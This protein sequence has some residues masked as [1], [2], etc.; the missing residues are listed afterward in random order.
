MAGTGNA[1]NNVLTGNDLANTLTGA[2]GADTLL[3]GVG[4]DV[5][6]AGDGADT[7]IYDAAD[8]LADGGIGLDT[9]QVLVANQA[10]N[11]TSLTTLAS[12][13]RLQLVNGGHVVTLD[14]ASL[15]ALSE[16]HTLVIEGGAS[17]SIV[18]GGGWT[19]L[20]DAGGYARY[21]Q[22]GAELDVAL[23][24]NR[25]GIG[26]V[27][28]SLVPGQSVIDLGSYGQLIAP[29]QV[30]GGSWFYYW[31]RSGDGTSNNTGSL[32]GGVDYA[33][34]DVL[35]GIFNQDINGNTGGGGNTDNTYRYATLSGV[36]LALPT[37]GGESSP[38]YGANGINA[39]QPGTSIGSSP[40]STGSNA[41]N[42][43]YNDYLAIWDA[44]NDTGTGININGTP[45]GWQTTYYWSATPSASGHAS[46][47]LV[48]GY[49]VDYGD[50]NGSH[51]ALQ[52][53]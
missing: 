5:L 43:T 13:E 30:D 37:A 2:A 14:V 34:H 39:Y 44:Y 33:T 32:N 27:V 52:V 53:L 1:L 42:S 7:L 10:L 6:H 40:A 28:A 25:A 29:V 17:D 18:A 45:A 21:T 46:V 26:T 50:V 41:V 19:A 3:G 15:L 48:N 16:S 9:L 35:D 38:F 12:L 24:V 4:A 49:V 51:V 31:D 22:G 23:A 8:T 47:G 20:S 11:L 36:H